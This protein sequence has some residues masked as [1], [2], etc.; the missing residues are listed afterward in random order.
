MVTQH[1]ENIAR[2]SYFD[3]LS[4]L[5]IAPGASGTVEALRNGLVAASALASELGVDASP[6]ER[7]ANAAW[8]GETVLGAEF[9]KLFT[10]ENALPLCESAW[11][12]RGSNVSAL[13]QLECRGRYMEAGLETAALRGIAEDHL[14]IEAAFMTVL[15]LQE[16]PTLAN[17]FFMEHLGRWLPALAASLREHP[18]ALLFRVMADVLDAT[19]EM[20][21][22]LNEE[23][24]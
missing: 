15:I 12:D 9:A 6:F 18:D 14:G 1:T 22:T 2:Q 5:F 20:E 4:R 24:R 16:K 3:A 19:V 17:Q 10:G 7:A 8:P 23:T 13:A 11:A 21:K